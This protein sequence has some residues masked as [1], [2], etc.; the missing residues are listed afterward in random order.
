M[1]D[2][3]IIIL[4]LKVFDWAKYRQKKGAIKLHTMLDYYGC[5]P[6]YLFMT[7]GKQSDDKH[8]HYMTLPKRS[9]VVADGGYQNFSMLYDWN[10]DDI[11]SQKIN[12][13]RN[14]RRIALE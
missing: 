1:L 6:S 13:P 9:V 7:E 8:A 11:Y 12:K 5:M 14:D 4:C 2:S 3:T 10:K